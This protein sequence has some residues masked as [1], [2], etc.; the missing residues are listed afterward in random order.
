MALLLRTH[1]KLARAMVKKTPTRSFLTSLGIA[2]GVASIVLILSLTASVSNLIATEVSDIGTDLIVVRP[3][4]TKDATTT[5]IEELTASN[6]LVSSTLTLEDV[7][8]ISAVDGVT[9]VAPIA[10]SVSSVTNSDN[11][12][13]SAT[14]LGTTPDFV[15]I[16]PLTL[17][18]GSFLSEKNAAT[19]LVVGSNISLQLFNT[20][21]PVGKTLEFRGT[22]YMII[23]VLEE[24]ESTINFDNVDLNNAIIMNIDALES[25]MGSVQI[26]QINVKAE[27]TAAL[28]ETS[29]KITAALTSSKSGDTNFSV[30]YGD[31]ITH[32]S[33]TLLSI[34]SA[35][36]A[37]VAGISLVVGG[38]GVMNVMLVSVV[39]RTREIGIRKA[40]GASSY[41]ILMQFIFESLILSFRG[42]LLG[43]IFGYILALFIST[44]APFSPV[45]TPE[46]LG[47][48]FATALIVGLIF[49]IYPA[50]K[51]ALKSPIESLKHYR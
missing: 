15:E 4:T 20:T 29:E 1:F 23:G 6:S 41:N 10:V 14:I 33:S 21:N 17:R 35:A 30:L 39:E 27:N 31:S 46:I 16:E 42:A 50:I 26:Q 37:L 51:A 25:I 28:E 38:I 49:G 11:E 2:V 48:V 9:V 47:I 22:R 24:I 36:L 13:T 45:I 5:A 18:Y 43:I 44:I 12:I 7:T 19:T 32:P 3:S 8:T 40:V 34:V